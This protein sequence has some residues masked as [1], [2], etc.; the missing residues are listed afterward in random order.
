MTDFYSMYSRHYY[1]NRALF[2]LLNGDI[3]LLLPLPELL[4]KGHYL[5]YQLFQLQG[6]VREFVEECQRF[7]LPVNGVNGFYAL[8]VIHTYRP[9]LGVKLGQ[10][11]V[12]VVGV[13]VLCDDRKI[14]AEY[15]CPNKI[16]GVAGLRSSEHGQKFLV[17]LVIQSEVIAMRSRVGKDNIPCRIS[18]LI[19]FSHKTAF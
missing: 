4:D 1:T 2:R 18:C 7:L 16:S 19:S 14:S 10:P 13:L 15:P 3:I 9:E 11:G 5:L 12:K 17:F 8:I 6:F